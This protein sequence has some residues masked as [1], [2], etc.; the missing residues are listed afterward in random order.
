[1]N[2]EILTDTSKVKQ[3]LLKKFPTWK[4]YDCPIPKEYWEL[5]DEYADSRIEISG[6][7]INDLA[8]MA[9]RK[10][11]ELIDLLKE[12]LDCWPYQYLGGELI[13]KIKKQI[14]DNQ[15]QNP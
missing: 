4:Y 1:M 13:A 14:A 5:F 11:K 2:K 15:T 12:C 7:D 9:E 6:I 10:E 8:A 3:F